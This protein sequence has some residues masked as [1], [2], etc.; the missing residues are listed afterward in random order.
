MDL[1]HPSATP[2]TADEP[3]VPGS[4]VVVETFVLGSV[5]AQVTYRAARRGLSGGEHPDAAA[6]ELAGVGPDGLLHSTSWRFA[7]GRIVLTY[8]ALPDPEPWTATVLRGAGRPPAAGADPLTPSPERVGDADVVAHA[9]RHLAF[10]HGTDPVV[11]ATAEQHPALWELL[12][13]HR[14]TVA[15]AFQER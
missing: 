2:P 7:E 15:G 14:P 4:A 10:L 1:R 12:D 5:D 8:A 9:C 13:A 11:A 6:R 3:I